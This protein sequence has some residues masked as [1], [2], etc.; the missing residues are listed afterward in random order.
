MTGWWMRVW[1]AWIVGIYASPAWGQTIGV[2][3]PDDP[4]FNQTVDLF[5]TDHPDVTVKRV[6]DAADAEAN[7]VVAVVA[8]ST[9]DAAAEA[10]ATALKAAKIPMI[11]SNADS[12]DV[13]RMGSGVFVSNA[14]LSRRAERLVA[15]LKAINGVQSI[16]LIFDNS[17]AEYANIV[18]ATAEAVGLQVPVNAGW[19][20]APDRAFLAS[21]FNEFDRAPRINRRAQRFQRLFGARTESAIDRKLGV[22]AVVV[23][24]DG[25]DSGKAVTGLRDAGITL[26]IFGTEAMATD[27][28]VAEAGREAADVFAITTY[29]ADF[30]N[31]RARGFAR[32]FDGTPGTDAVLLYE[33]L[34]LATAGV[35]DVRETEKAKE[36]PGSVTGEAIASDLASRQFADQAVEGLSGLLY[37]DVDGVAQRDPWMLVLDRGRFRPAYSQLRPIVDPRELWK[38]SHSDDEEAAEE[39]EPEPNNRRRARR[40]ARNDV[41]TPVEMATG[42]TV[43]VG[44]RLYHRTAVVYAGIDFFRVNEVDVASQAF[45][46]ELFLWFRWQG[47]VD[48]DNITFLNQINTE[49]SF[50]QVVRQDLES[51]VKYI[52]YKVKGRFLTPFDLH[53]FPFDQ[54]RLPVE[55]S[56]ATL[57]SRDLMLV[58][59]YDRL[60]QEEIRAIYPEEWSYVGRRDASATYAPTTTYGDPAY[61]GLASRSEFSVYHTEIVLDRILFPYLITLF[62]PLAIMIGISLFV[63]L[64]PPSQFDARLTLVMTALLSVVVFHLAQGE[65]LPSVGYLMRADQYFMVAYLLLFVLIIKTVLVNL[66]MGRLSNA[67]IARGEWVFAIAFIPATFLLYGTL[68]FDSP[69]EWVAERYLRPPPP[70]GIDTV[71]TPETPVSGQ[72]AATT[73]DGDDATAAVETPAR[74]ERDPNE[75]YA[76]CNGET[77]A[78]STLLQPILEDMAAIEIPYTQDKTGGDQLRDCSGNF[79]RVSSEVANQCV[80]ARPYLAASEGVVPW[81]NP[82]GK[83]NV[84]QGTHQKW[85]A[86]GKNYEARDTRGTARWYDKQGLFTPLYHDNKQSL[87]NASSALE[88][89]RNTIKPG[90]VLWYAK[91]GK[92]FTEKYGKEPLFTRGVGIRHMGVVHSVQR[93]PESGDVVG[94]KL[95]HGRKDDP[96]APDNDITEHKWDAWRGQPPFGNGPDPLVG[97]APLLPDTP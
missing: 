51:P 93:D 14:T 31:V 16:G 9:D 11:A 6:A 89:F 2:I 56:H 42:R 91:S 26:P 34:E 52:C 65:D 8:H 27:A 80:D 68:S 33:A 92:Y 13:A 1:L 15:Y 67:M 5:Q 63:V 82:P 30:A 58:V 64:I 29:S 70:E 86:D 60:S 88:A 24:G 17:E 35:R 87:T 40:R 85:T 7:S 37:F 71:V 32:R 28:F 39:P 96:K 46:V 23:L 95:Y 25:E 74:I 21:S 53:D 36:S 41:Q 44:Q 78:L 4:A 62:L 10:T 59:D 48:I 18:K 76:K 3:A 20:S 50:F 73:E 66:L 72:Q 49:D 54:Q 61:E 45:D 43:K 84:F 38:A 69:L 90:M 55:L 79:L 22:G 12:A 57:D 75:L 47:D 19:D 77:M 81:K 94:Y 97:W 83:Q